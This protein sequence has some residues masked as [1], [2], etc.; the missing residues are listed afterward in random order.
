M[1]APIRFTW[2]GE[3]MVPLPRF[4]KAC[5]A[6]F[7]IGETYQ[8][9]VQEERSWASHRHYF[10]AVHE[11]WLNLPEDLAEQFPTEEHLRKRA[12]IK[13]G[14]SEHR[15][16]VASSKA[17]AVRL[18]A[19]IRPS[20]EYA[21]VTVDGAVV[22]VWTARSQSV[23]AMGKQ[24]FQESKNKVLDVLAEMIGIQP[25]TLTRNVGRAA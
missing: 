20:D 6:E 4:A 7:T 1:T 10:A 25:E 24:V 23:H 5:D 12:L 18:A 21:L 15:Q 2:D 13:A 11:A 9:V 22:N 17:E 16:F 19:F 3:S 14:F 8:M